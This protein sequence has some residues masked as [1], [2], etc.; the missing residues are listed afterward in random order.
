MKKVYFCKYDDEKHKEKIES[1]AVKSIEVLFDE[2]EYVSAEHIE[3]LVSE[4]QKLS[5]NIVFSQLK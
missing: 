2:F 3:K 4:I 1:A 5:R